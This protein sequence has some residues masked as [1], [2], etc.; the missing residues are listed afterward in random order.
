MPL[1]ALNRVQIDDRI[2]IDDS[3][4]SSSKPTTWKS[5]SKWIN[6]V[7]FNKKFLERSDN[8][9]KQQM[10]LLMNFLFGYTQR[11]KTQ[12]TRSL[13]TLEFQYKK[14]FF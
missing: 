12:L 2:Q 8:K 3:S 10:I 11:K 6:F 9:K 5:I 14:N 1:E 13:A 7:H 4:V